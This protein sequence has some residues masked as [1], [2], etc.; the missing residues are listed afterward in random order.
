MHI[1]DINLLNRIRE[2][3]ISTST[4]ADV[5]DGMKTG[6]VLTHRLT[7]VN[8]NDYYI[9][10]YAYTVRW[11]II[12]K[13]SDITAPMPSTWEQVKDFLVPEIDNGE[14]RIYVAGAGDCL[15]DAAL[16]GGMSCTYFA[17]LGFAGVITGG[18]VRDAEDLQP[19]IM[20]VIATNLIPT[21]TQGAW[22]VA[23]TGGS[24]RIE[25]MTIRT[26]DLIVADNN[27]VVVIPPQNSAAVMNTAVAV[28]HTE[29]KMLTDIRN[30]VRLPDLIEST[31]RI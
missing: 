9:A 31:G 24:C 12:R 6:G 14:N 30:G 23:E 1:A 21:D 18:A 28:H 11:Q 22:Y 5:M 10:G 4:F 19:L 15:Y 29:N 20:P 13:G 2:Y 8:M 16:A 7:S 3:R 17:G 26:G 25:Q 27:G